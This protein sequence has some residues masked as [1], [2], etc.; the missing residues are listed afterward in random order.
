MSS[1]TKLQLEA[2]TKLALQKEHSLFS[3]LIISFNFFQVGDVV[4]QNHTYC[5]V[6]AARKLA[7]PSSIAQR[8]DLIISLNTPG[9]WMLS[10]VK[11][12]SRFCIYYVV[13]V[14]HSMELYV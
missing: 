13:N 12:L 14:V 5:V 9:K 11:D 4:V 7:L 8:K 1:Y 6:G 3:N 2:C 10:N